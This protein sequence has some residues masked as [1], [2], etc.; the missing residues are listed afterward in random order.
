MARTIN[1]STHRRRFLGIVL[2]AALLGLFATNSLAEPQLENSIDAST[3]IALLPDSSQLALSPD[4]ELLPGRAGAQALDNV[5]LEQR[6]HELEQQLYDVQQS[7]ELSADPTIEQAGYQG[8]MMSAHDQHW[9]GHR[10]RNSRYPT[11]AWGG[12]MQLDTGWISQDAASKAA[13]G[14]IDAQ[15]GLRRVR[16][17]VRGNVQRNLSYLIDLDFAATGHPSFRDAMF[18]AHEL[19]AVQNFRVGYYQQPFGLDAMTSGRELIFLE[20][21]LPF[22]FDPFRQTGFG[23]Y[24]NFVEKAG[25]WAVSAYRFPTD[26]FGVSEG[27]SG[28]WAVASRTTAKLID[29]NGG[30]EMVHVGLNYSVGDPGTNMVRYSIQPGFFVTDPTDP[31][32]AGGVPTIVDTGDIPTQ[33]FNLFGAELAA[34]YGSLNFQS[35]LKGSVVDQIDG[36]TLG[37]WGAYAQVAWV[38]TGEVH[39]YDAERGAFRRVIP[40]RDTTFGHLSEGAWEVAA[41]WSYIDLNDENIA[42]GRAYSGIIGINRYLSRYVKFQFN[43]IRVLSDDATFGD[44]G[45]TVVALRSQAEF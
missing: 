43:A 9:G 25:S 11:V 41:G 26:E 39:P 8:P 13:F 17:N 20:R 31:G 33:V 14:N 10:F 1:L 21:L 3:D 28:G 42:G 4:L 23:C 24:G 22:A 12:F 30:D 37:F 5:R 35:E 40:H 34:Q 18:T 44:T 27:E 7:L 16:L 19:D 2:C 38:I 15:T 45:T 29:N 36:P 6:V 32:T